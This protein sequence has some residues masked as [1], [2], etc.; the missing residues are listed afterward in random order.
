VYKLTKDGV[1]TILYSFTDGADGALPRGGLVLDTAGNLYGTTSA[2]GTGGYGVVFKMDAAGNEAV[3]YS[4]TGGADGGEPDGRLF[5]DG[6]GNI[7]G[8]TLSGGTSGNGVVFKLDTTGKESVLYN[9]AGSPDGSSPN[10]GLLQNVANTFYGTTTGGGNLDCGSS[11]KPVGCGTVFKLDTSGNETVL[12][13]FTGGDDGADGAF[14]LTS[15]IQ[16]SAG[17]L[18]GTTAA[19]SPGPCYDIINPNPRPGSFIIHCG[20]VFKVDGTGT[21]TVLHH[22]AGQ[23]DGASP[24]G[25]LII[26]WAGNLY[27]TTPYGGTGHCLAFGTPDVNV[28]C[29]TIYKVDWNGNETVLYSFSSPGI[30]PEGGMVADASGNLYGTTHGSVFEFTGAIHGVSISPSA[31]T[32]AEG[33]SQTFTV[34]KKDPNNPGVSWSITS[35]CD[36]GPACQGTLTAMTPT[37]VTYNAPTS[38]TAGNPITIVATS[39]ADSNTS[40]TATVTITGNVNLTDFT[41]T[42]ATASLA[43]QSGTQETQVTDVITIAPQGGPFTS[44]V[45]LTCQVGPSP[46]LGCSLSPTSVTLGS[47][48]ATTMLTVI[49]PSGI[50]ALR[51]FNDLRAEKQKFAALFAVTIL[52]MVLIVGLKNDRR[53]VWAFQ[54]LVLLLIALA[55]GCGGGSSM[56]ITKN[57]TV[58]V[59]GSGNA[60]ALQHTAQINVSVQ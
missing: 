50:A 11:T 25:D 55:A 23:N 15:L 41:L 27:G 34:K 20:T 30:A 17:N 9:F 12:Y 28:G 24:Q 47:N 5:I 8:T 33:S 46:D 21:E 19:G 32:L 59:T 43:A 37:S 6:A 36:F 14:P 40:D 52:G 53:Q 29:G 49:V 60:G 7:Y 42:P 54:G 48:S 45:Q 1:E 16:D 3:L 2:G 4:F 26:D 18:Y 39:I 31:V 38:S 22:F 58:T 44:A 56:T 10:A 57:Y 35:P 13:R 51:P